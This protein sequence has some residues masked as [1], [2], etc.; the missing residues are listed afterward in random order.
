MSATELVQNLYDVHTRVRDILKNV[1]DE[2]D[3]ENVTVPAPKYNIGDEVCCMIQRLKDC[4][5]NSSTTM[6]RT[7]CHYRA[8][9]AVTYANHEGWTQAS[10]SCRTTA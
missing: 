7:I 2:R 8:T 10:C 5:E 6:E 3:V 4:H 9:L 1:N